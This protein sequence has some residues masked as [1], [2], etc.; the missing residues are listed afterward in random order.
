M[1]VGFT[2]LIVTQL[3]HQIIWI[4]LMIVYRKLQTWN[5]CYSRLEFQLNFY[6]QACCLKHF[7]ISSHFPS[8]KGFVSMKHFM[9]VS[10]VRQHNQN[11]ALLCVN[12]GLLLLFTMNKGCEM[13]AKTYLHIHANTLVH[14]NLIGMK[15]SFDRAAEVCKLYFYNH[16][17]LSGQYQQV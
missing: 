5:Y 8:Q 15:R 16:H 10:V 4:S 6:F 1:F 9:C 2:F 12:K 3:F 7:C 17:D 11:G 13:S 14:N